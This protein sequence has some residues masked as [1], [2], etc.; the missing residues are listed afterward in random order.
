MQSAPLRLFPSD[1]SAHFL[2]QEEFGVKFVYAWHSLHGYWAGVAI[3]S[4]PAMPYGAQLVMPQP[5]PGI[6]NFSSSAC[7]GP[8]VCLAIFNQLVDHTLQN[9]HHMTEICIAVT[10]Q[11]RKE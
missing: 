6:Q 7:R 4:S 8:P 5:T 10:L 11:G 9:M 1:G 3:G 2:L